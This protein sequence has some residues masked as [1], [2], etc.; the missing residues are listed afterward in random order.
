MHFTG[1]QYLS[2]VILF[3]LAWAIYWPAVNGFF[4]SDDFVFLYRIQQS[5]YVPYSGM[6]FRPASQLLLWL[7]FQLWHL[8]P[9]P[10]FIISICFHLFNTC[11]VFFLSKKI[12]P[13]FTFNQQY[14]TAALFMIYPF[15]CET[16]FWIS[17]QGV[18]AAT[19]FILLTMLSHV[20]IQSLAWRAFMVS[21]FFGVSLLFYESAWCVPLILIVYDLKINSLPIKKIFVRMVPVFG[22]FILYSVWRWISVHQF[23]YDYGNKKGLVDSLFLVPS[24]LVMLV[25]RAVM[26]PMQSTTTFVA[27]SGVIILILFA[28]YSIKKKSISPLSNPLMFVGLSFFICLTPFIKYGIN[29]HNIEEGRYLYLA[30]VFLVLFFVMLLSKAASFMAYQ[31]GIG[32]LSV[33]FLVLLNIYSLHWKEAY[34]ITKNYSKAINTANGDSLA[35]VNV[36]TDKYGAYTFRNGFE[37]CTRLF[38]KTKNV[39]VYNFVA[40]PAEKKFNPLETNAK[41][42]ETYDSIETINDSTVVFRKVKLLKIGSDSLYYNMRNIVVFESNKIVVLF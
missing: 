13:G 41:K 26:I 25:G 16:I 12:S 39:A 18:L 37:Q 9:R 38:S 2:I 14:I 5:G 7:N 30:S 36:P 31:F 1:R 17:A 42:T 4:V 35:G 34:S 24:H 33:C 40:I 23:F 28:I 19:S 27:W 29:I 20:T 10:Y 11:L 22:V 21:I 3:V 6:F 32:I 15:A 8:N